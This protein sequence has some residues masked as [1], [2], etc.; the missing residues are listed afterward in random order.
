[1]KRATLVQLVVS[2]LLGVLALIIVLQNTDPV[3][4]RVLF[5]TVTMSGAL[6]LLCTLAIGFITGVAAAMVVIRRRA[7]SK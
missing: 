7:A 2:I 3:E 5:T 4:T 1:M 6:L